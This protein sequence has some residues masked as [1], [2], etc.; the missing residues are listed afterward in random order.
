[1]IEKPHAI[2]TEDEGIWIDFEGEVP[3]VGD[4]INVSLMAREYEIPL[5]LSSQEWVVYKVSWF[6]CSWRKEPFP[7]PNQDTTTISQA[8]VFIKPVA[9]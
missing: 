1:M 4:Q 9:L 6:I 3:R 5:E 2:I 7:S 8:R